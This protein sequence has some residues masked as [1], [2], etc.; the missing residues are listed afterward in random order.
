M[1]YEYPPP[2]DGLTPGPYELTKAQTKIGNQI[3]YLS[4]G[5]KKAPHQTEEGVTVYRTG[6]SIPI[7]KAYGLTA[8]KAFRKYKKIKKTEEIDIVHGHGQLPFYFHIYKKLTRDPVPYVF[9]LHITSK[10][11]EQQKKHYK[12]RTRFKAILSWRL[13]NL[14]ERMG[15]QIAN[16]VIA[17]SESVKK[18]AI[19][20]YKVAPEKIIVAENGVNFERFNKTIDG[21]K[22]REELGLSSSDKLLLFVGKLDYRKNI[23]AFLELIK[24][25]PKHYH[26]MLV[27]SHNKKY[28]KSIRQNIK[29]FNL[30]NR[31]FLTGYVE[32][33]DLPEYYAASDAFVL[34]SRYEGLP[35]VVLEALAI[36]LP[37]FST[38]SFSCNPKLER[39]IGWIEENDPESAAENVRRRLESSVGKILDNK[40]FKQS[41][42]WDSTALFIQDIY[43][44]II[45]KINQN[46]E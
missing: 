20:Y 22:K 1:C 9:H 11:R 2:W 24:N 19:Q 40:D 16:R 37:V 43:R 4:G 6:R 41:F 27:G 42:S 45:K 15:C 10:G 23:L 12:W 46:N 29:E 28:V 36:D 18:E 13:N 30:E 3:I 38:R 32:Y 26:L 34:L 7:I 25:L 17:V 8:F 39:M 35:K 31:V 21:K 5:K 33:L 14:C 44:S